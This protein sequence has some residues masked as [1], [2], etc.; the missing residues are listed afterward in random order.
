MAVLDPISEATARSKTRLLL[1][2]THPD[3]N[4]GYSKVSYNLLK[5]LG[6]KEDIEVVQYGFQRFS[7]EDVNKRMHNIPPSVIVYDAAKAEVPSLQGFGFA[8]FREFVRLSKPDVI[9]IFND[10]QVVTNFLIELKREPQIL[11]PSTKV[12]VYLDQVYPTQRID[13]LNVINGVADHIITFTEYWRKDLLRQGVTKPVSTLMHA[14]DSDLFKP[15]NLPPKPVEAPMVVLN[16]NRNQPRKRLD[17]TAIAM[18]RVFK[19]RPDANIA[20]LFGADAKNGAWDVPFIFQTEMLKAF[21]PEEVAKYG[22]RFA[23]V[24]NAGKM[25]DEEVNMLY[26]Q[27]DVGLNTA[28]GEG[29]GLNQ[30]E[31][32]GVG[33]PQIAGA[34][35]GM[36]EFLNESNSILVKPKLYI[37]AD[38]TSEVTGGEVS[39]LDP[40]EVADAI[41]HYYDNPALREE[42]GLKARAEIAELRWIDG[43]QYI[44]GLAPC[45]ENRDSAIPR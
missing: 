15:L 13:L 8:N 17:L 37:Y 33:K 40:D 32:A 16:L 36:T 35:G 19:K 1:V 26:N 4:T 10:A 23:T 25:T 21:S 9:V 31:H 7:Q 22:E 18:A 44:T 20:F 12:I 34:I 43:H 28:S 24:N 5:H 41:L 3:Q 29:V 2:S 30:L 14:F 45:G 42:H 27:T 6:T 39:L 11:Q 38:Q